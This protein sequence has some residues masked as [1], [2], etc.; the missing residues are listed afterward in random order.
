MLASQKFVK[1]MKK[2]F[3]FAYRKLNCSSFLCFPYV[4]CVKCDGIIKKKSLCE[5]KRVRIKTYA[6]LVLIV[7][8]KKNR[9]YD[10]I[11]SI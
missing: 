7:D 1:K 8:S 10:D 11:N 5:M 4:S 2:F 9:L 6:G 3:D